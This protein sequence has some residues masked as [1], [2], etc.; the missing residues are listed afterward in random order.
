MMNGHSVR[1]TTRVG[2]VASLTVAGV[3]GTCLPATASPT[4]VS[5]SSV[6]VT[7]SRAVSTMTDSQGNSRPLAAVSEGTAGSAAEARSWSAL[8]RAAKEA[9]RK[10]PALW[11]KAVSGAKKGYAY[12]QNS[13]WPAIKFTVQVISYSITAWDIWNLFR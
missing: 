11:D 1:W 6:S 7:S 13:V 10:V 9:I 3:L 4:T 2:V 8:L 12:F 5:A